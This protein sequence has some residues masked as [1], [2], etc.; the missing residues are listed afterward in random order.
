MNRAHLA[1]L[2]LAFSFITIQAQTVHPEV[3]PKLSSPVP[4]DAGIERRIEN[5]LRKMTLE[6]KA[7]QVIQA[8]ITTVKPE[9]I[10]TYHLGS[11]LNGGG[12]FPGAADGRNAK[13]KDYLALAD[14][15]YA[16]SMDT[17]DGGQAIPI[18]W[19]SDAVHGH[20]NV[21]GA[22][23]FPHNIGLGATRNYDLI[24]RIGEITAIEMSVTGIS[25]DFSPVVAVTRD[26][27]WGRTYETYSED[28]GIVRLAAA[29]IIEGLQGKP[30]TKA[31]LGPGKVIGTAKHF[32]GDGG[33]VDGKD[34]GDNVVPEAALRDIHGAGY[35][36]AFQ[37]GAQGVMGSQ[38]G[39]FGVELHGSRAFLTDVLKS[40][41]GFDGILVGDWNAHGQVPGCSNASCAQSLNAGL[42]MF[43]VPDDWK[44]LHGN[45]VAQVKSGA[46]PMARLDDAVRRILRVKMR[47]GLFSAGKPSQRPFAKKPELFGSA[48]HRQV[49]RQAVRESLVL[50]KNDGVLPIRPAQNVLVAGDGA[51]NIPKQAG[52]WTVT[53]QGTDTTNENFPGGTSIWDGIRAA[54]EAGGGR[55]TLSADGTFTDKPNVAV[56]VFGE[57]PYAEWEGDLRSIVYDNPK[58]ITLVRRLRAAGVPVVSVFLSGRPLWVNPYLNASNAFVAAWLPGSEG[59]GV[60]DVLSGAA[61]FKGKLSFSWPK[62]P[63]QVVLNQGDPGYDPLFPLGFG[64]T[65]KD[66]GDLPML[67]VDTTGVDPARVFFT[68]GPAE[69]WELVADKEIAQQEEA[70]G[71]RVLAW[72]GGAR[73]GVSLRSKQP[74]SLA[75][76]NNAGKALAIDV[77]LEKSPSGP[78][79]LTMGCGELCGGTLDVSGR[80]KALPVGVW[81]TIHIPLRCFAA[82]GADMS[83]IDTPF[84]LATD[85]Q[86]TLRFADIEVVRGAGPAACN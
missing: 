75:A 46:V 86:L 67:P 7:G 84:H 18:I 60:A 1:I 44:A 73:R 36:G 69:G 40:Q 43:M 8:S 31:F 48:A 37:S 62:L 19:G 27:R 72:P 34:Q 85:G 23:V 12:G 71:R 26:D 6:E 17:S 30:G 38:S 50:L 22:T 10:K 29:N 33:T 39:W 55:A 13:P 57:N 47:A 56:V 2:S 11:V 21:V 59:G 68:A 15:Y 49:A 83:R 24:K 77:M 45:I 80:I 28:P 81:K 20:S 66:R 70:G 35:V 78:L 41:M 51:H 64:L 25:W 3:W 53:W 61:D 54:V 52:G 76:D 63:T 82:A 32:L 14:A 42:D 65:Y 58:D 4:R 79:F 9:D 5:I 74:V 16:A